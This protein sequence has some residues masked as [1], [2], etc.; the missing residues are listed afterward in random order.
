MQLFEKPH[1]PILPGIS[2]IAT[3]LR[4][5]AGRKQVCY[6]M[7]SVKRKKAALPSDVRL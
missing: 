6:R 5:F 2:V 3:V 4:S 1:S 7:L